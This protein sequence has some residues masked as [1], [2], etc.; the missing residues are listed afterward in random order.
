MEYIALISLYIMMASSI[1]YDTSLKVS[2]QILLDLYKVQFSE[3]TNLKHKCFSI[4]IVAK[5]I[6]AKQNKKSYQY[7]QM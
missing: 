2:N 7:K 4:I 5:E 6:K 3:E 1:I